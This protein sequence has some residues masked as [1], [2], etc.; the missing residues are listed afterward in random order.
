M[1]KGPK[2]HGSAS[3]V[4]SF[5]REINVSRRENKK[6]DAR[7]KSPVMKINRCDCEKHGI[8]RKIEKTY[9]IRTITAE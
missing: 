3:A 4:K 1:K 5:E 9:N 7:E 8:N 6:H 2:I